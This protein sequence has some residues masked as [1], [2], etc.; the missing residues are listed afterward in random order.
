MSSASIAM[1]VASQT[2][3]CVVCGQTNAQVLYRPRHSPGSV[4]RCLNC[5]CVYISRVEDQRALIFDGPVTDAQHTALLTSSNLNDLAGCWELSL[6]P[7]KE[8]E[9]EAIRVNAAHSL[10][11]IERYRPAKGHLLDFGCG[12][13][14]FLSVAKERGWAIF[15]L[16]PLPGHALYARATTGAQVITDT[17][18]DNTFLSG[19]FDAIT[20]FQV[21]EHL[22]NPGV[23]LKRLYRILKPG[24]V[25]LIEVPNIDT[26]SIRLLGPRHRHFVIDHLNF[27]SAHTL[28]QLLQRNGFEI[29]ESFYPTRRMTV[30]HLVDDWGARFLPRRAVKLLSTGAQRVGLYRR[31]I[32]LNLRDIVTVVARRPV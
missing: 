2:R 25:L 28:G 30:R 3:P 9:Q 16:E 13:G 17:L 5:G 27:F 22:P 18:R 23:D 6:L 21:F 24:G 7:S 15:G 26:W 19:Y 31:M 1:T 11:K 4:A 8:N 32:G 14:H 20:A 10:A 12:W 29:L